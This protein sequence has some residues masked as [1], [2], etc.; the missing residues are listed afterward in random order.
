MIYMEH[1]YMWKYMDTFS[2]FLVCN[3]VS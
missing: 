1:S 2:V 3:L